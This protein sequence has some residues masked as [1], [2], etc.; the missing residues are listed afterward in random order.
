MHLQTELDQTSALFLTIQYDV[1]A[2]V[3]STGGPE[4]QHSSVIPDC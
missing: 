3:I 4:V 1:F 2:R